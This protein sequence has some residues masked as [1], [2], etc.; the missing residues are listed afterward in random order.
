MK[1]LERLITLAVCTRTKQISL[2]YVS[3]SIEYAF[4]LLSWLIDISNTTEERIV[5]L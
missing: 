1:T 5:H 4:K 2:I 3:T